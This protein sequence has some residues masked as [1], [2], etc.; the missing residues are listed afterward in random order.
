ML[1]EIPPPP[2]RDGALF[3]RPPEVEL[4]DDAARNGDLKRVKELVQQLPHSPRP[5][6]IT[7]AIERH[8]LDMVQFLLDENVTTR[9]ALLP[10]E[11]AVRCGAFEVL[12]LFLQ[13]GWDINKPLHRNEPPVLSIPLCTGDKE[14]VIW[15]LDHGADPNAR[16]AWDY[17]PTSQAMLGAP[18]DLIDYLFTHGADARRGEL[19]QYAVL[20]DTPDALD[21]VRRAVEHGAPI[22][23][24]KYEDEP[25]V[26]RERE[27]FGLGTPLYRAAEF[28]RV[29]I[30]KYLLE[31]GADPLKLDSR[32]KKPRYWADIKGHPAVGIALIHAE[33]QWSKMLPKEMSNL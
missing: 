31:Q 16:C 29:E 21:I 5:S 26:F 25:K 8:D 17:T 4:C 2:P 20:R 24:V 9:D 22:N 11:D 30:V 3:Y 28:G 6:S 7:T 19:L 15:L 33:D 14:M 12:E 18:L 10:F 32:G 1:P 13:R 27:P 23:K